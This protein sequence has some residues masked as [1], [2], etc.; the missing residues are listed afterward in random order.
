TALK[1]R[2]LALRGDY[3]NALTAAQSVIDGSGLSLATFSNYMS[4]FHTDSNAPDSEVIFKLKQVNG[5]LK[6]GT[7]WASVNS[8]VAGSPF[9]EI[10]RGLFNDLNTTDD[11]SAT[12]VTITNIA[13][14]SA[15][16]GGSIL[17]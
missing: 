1:A 8:T 13:A 11:A 12:T 17:T 6:V 3:T 2:T 14:F 7:V 4:V 5:G 16:N 15:A 10:G 9:Y